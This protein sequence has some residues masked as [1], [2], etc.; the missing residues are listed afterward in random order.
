MKVYTPVQA[1]RGH[2]PLL[3][4]IIF[5]AVISSPLTFAQTSAFTF[6]GRL[7]DNITTANG[8]YDFEFYLYSTATGAGQISP[9]PQTRTGVSVTNGIFTVSL[10]FGQA[11]L[12]SGTDR[13]LEIRVKRPVDAIYTPL[14]PRP[15]LTS[16]PYSVSALQANALSPTASINISG[17][18]RTSNLIRTGS[19][20]GTSETPSNASGGY[21]GL[22]LRRIN[23]GSPTAG[24]VV[25]R[26]DVLMLQR[27]G[28][29]AG[30]RIAFP[31]NAGPQ[32]AHC[33]GITGSNTVVSARLRSLSVAGALVVFTNAQNVEFMQCSFGALFSNGHLTQVTLQRDF[34]D[35]VWA[36]TLTSTFN[37]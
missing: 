20:T 3:F 21:S 22:I 16:S 12:T 23:S 11:Q 8:T 15:Q 32:T 31:A 36:G 25:A 30:W 26:T 6:Q 27:D 1:V 5:A 18:I 9:I 28:T 10:D 24:L 29:D 14:S 17:N 33:I 4:I 35:Y 2:V 37:Q 34:G 19:E 7:T 13:Y